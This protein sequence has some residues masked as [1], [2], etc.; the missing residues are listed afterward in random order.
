M[1]KNML[2]FIDCVCLLKTPTVP[3]TVSIKRDFRADS[4]M[5]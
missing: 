5:V 1:L 4:K 3:D 2:P